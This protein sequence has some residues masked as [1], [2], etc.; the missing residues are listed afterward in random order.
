MRKVDMLDIPVGQMFF[1]YRFQGVKTLGLFAW[2]Q[3]ELIW[4]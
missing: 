2:I 1:W 4:G 3:T